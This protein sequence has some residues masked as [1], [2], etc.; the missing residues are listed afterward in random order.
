MIKTNNG[1]YSSNKI[2]N[3]E[4]LAKKI[5]YL[6]DKGKTIGLCTGSFDLLHPGHITHLEAAKKNCDILVVCVASDGFNHKKTKKRGRPL[7]SKKV[8]AYS[9]ANL[10]SVDYV[11]YNDDTKE[12]IQLI[13]PNFLIKGSDYIENTNS[14]LEEQKTLIKELNGKFLNTIQ[15]K[16][17]TSEIIK[18][19]KRE[20]ED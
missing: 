14:D 15:E 13:K 3:Y 6:K 18:Y 11:V 5:E 16:L 7:F 1:E 10:S 9:V 12:I 8:R 19:I 4:K 20:V 2:L 17:A